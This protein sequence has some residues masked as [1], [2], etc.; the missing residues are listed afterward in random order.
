MND[1]SRE[2]IRERLGNIDQI[3]DII[4]GAQLRD[5]DNRLGKL[6]ADVSSI[7][8]EMRD[9][10]EQIRT[11]FTTE[12]KSAVDAIEKKLKSSN[13]THHEECA[14]LR[15]QVDRLNRKFTSSLQSLDETLDAQTSS[16][17]N[18]LA[19]TKNQLQDDAVSLKGLV[20]EELEKR[21]AQLRDTKVA[22][23]DMAEVLFEMGMRLKGSEFIPKLREVA[24]G[25]EHVPLIETRKLSGE[26]M[27]SNQG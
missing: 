20:L 27:Y 17:R 23:E 2:E 9:R 15:Q 14:D 4:F 26:W 11:S 22:R 5:Y 8:R 6:E 12:L 19:Q 18:E 1:I 25:D 13:L 24:D 10:T 7:Q 16:L 3:R 21:F